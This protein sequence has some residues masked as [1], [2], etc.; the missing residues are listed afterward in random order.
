MQHGRLHDTCGHALMVQ[1]QL[2]KSEHTASWAL[3]TDN[4]DE[5]CDGLETGLQIRLHTCHAC[6]ASQICTSTHKLCAS[7]WQALAPHCCTNIS[8][9]GL[10]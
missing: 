6:L 2:G 3:Y 9:K 5:E 8:Q 10:F 4:S 7:A 1:L